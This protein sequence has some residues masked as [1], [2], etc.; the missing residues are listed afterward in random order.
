MEV[1]NST[2][3]SLAAAVNVNVSETRSDVMTGSQFWNRARYFEREV[4]SIFR[5]RGAALEHNAPLARNQVAV[6][7]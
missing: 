6:P 7:N 3:H 5:V 1:A 4:A 2:S